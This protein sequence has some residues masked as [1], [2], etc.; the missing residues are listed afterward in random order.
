MGDRFVAGY[1]LQGLSSFAH[2]LTCLVVSAGT[3]LANVVEVV[4]VSPL[5]PCEEKI[6]EAYSAVASECQTLFGT[7]YPHEG[8]MRKE[9]L[10]YREIMCLGR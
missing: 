8:A 9:V 4:V 5:S 1:S 2:T 10:L 7:H 3:V 6:D